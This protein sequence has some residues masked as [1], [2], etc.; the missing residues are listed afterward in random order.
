MK[1]FS[2][3]LQHFVN[4]GK[5][6]KFDVPSEQVATILRSGLLV[7]AFKNY[8]S[9]EYLVIDQ[10]ELLD[11]IYSAER[12]VG[13]KTST[14]S[15]AIFFIANPMLSERWLEEAAVSST[16]VELQVNDLGLA[17]HHI[18]LFEETTSNGVPYSEYVRELFNLPL[19]LQPISVAMIGEPQT[20]VREVDNELLEWE[21]V[22]INEY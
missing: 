6:N 2:Q 17:V 4:R 16:I 19:H 18:D 11:Q 3:L 12:K 15:F 21:R 5:A 7:D 20:A 14:F 13:D 1:S 8:K 9:I 22:H 10:P